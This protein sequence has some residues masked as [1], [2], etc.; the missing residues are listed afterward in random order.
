M[1]GLA[2]FSAFTGFTVSSADT[3]TGDF[4]SLG[5]GTGATRFFRSLQRPAN[6]IGMMIG[7]PNPSPAYRTLLMDVPIGILQEGV[8]PNTRAILVDSIMHWF[9]LFSGVEGK[10]APYISPTSYALF[11]ARPNPTS[12]GTSF[13]YQLPTSKHASLVVYNVAGQVVRTLVNAEVPAGYHR[14]RWDGHDE[15]GAK[16]AAG[17]YLVRFEAGDYR[18]TKKAVVVR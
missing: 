17:V 15:S 4:D 5:V 13:E 10:E 16:V 8:A 2:Y 7:Y 6:N 11:G 12:E 14:A 9:Q 3:G 18:A 1:F